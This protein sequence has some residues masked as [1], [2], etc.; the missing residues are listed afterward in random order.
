MRKILL[1]FAGV[2][3]VAVGIA[4]IVAGLGGWT[5]CFN[6]SLVGVGI[7]VFALGLMF[8]DKCHLSI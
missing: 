1:K 8:W 6:A 2:F 4:W 3:F 7:T 5:P